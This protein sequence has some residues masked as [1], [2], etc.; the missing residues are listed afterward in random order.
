MTEIEFYNYTKEK[1]NSLAEE[2]GVK[3]L[4][5]YYELTDF[6]KGSFLNAYEGINQV[7]AQLAFHAQNATML[8]NIVKFESNISFLDSVLCGFDPAEFLNKYSK[9]SEVV[10]TLRYSDA[11]PDGLRWNT[12][13][14]NTRPDQ[15]IIR[16]AEALIYGAI[17][18]RSFKTKKDVLDDL[19]S[20]Y[21]NKDYEKLIRYFRTNN[22]KGFSVA[23]TCDFLK[24]LD[25]AFSDLPKPDVHIKHT[26]CAFY[27]RD[28]NY[29]S[30]EK[31]ELECIQD[32]QNITK[33]V[34]ESLPNEHL[35]VYKLDKMI[36]LICSSKFYLDHIE[37]PKSDYL[38][39]IRAN[40]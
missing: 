28:K 32:M 23:L 2:R 21:P 37:D 31:R 6:A 19:L 9:S 34:N 33:V 8:S 30:S 16:Y 25:E 18:L 29:Y 14:S 4:N 27:N 3:N 7:F 40:N 36:W 1:L 26:L 13:K 35:T 5:R 15:L 39:G 24:E 22:P 12:Q 11:N 38:S 17:Y 20:H 10:E